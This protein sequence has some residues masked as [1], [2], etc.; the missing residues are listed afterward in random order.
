MP[1]TIADRVGVV[2]IGRN[3]GER[4]VACLRSAAG[5]GGPVVYVDSASTDGSVA[6]ARRLGADTVALDMAL[7]FT[8][9]RARNAGLARLRE[10]AP[11]VE[12]V[13]FVDADCTLA[14]GWLAVATRFLAS[15]PHV[16]VVCG[17]RRE[18]HPDA[19]VYN[20]MCDLEWDTPVGR[21]LACGG[22]ALMR[23]DA[24]AAVGG[25]NPALIAGEEPELCVRLREAGWEIWRHDAEM[26]LHEAD[27]TRFGQWWRRTLR[28]G[29]AFAEVSHLHRRSAR[30][31]WAHETRRA[32]AWGAVLPAAVLLAAA[33]E[34]MALA[35]LAIYPLQVVRL[36]LRRGGAAPRDWA[37]AGFTVLGRFAEC[38]G[39]WRFVRSR[40]QRRQGPLIE[41]KS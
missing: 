18:R 40:L 21:A 13:Q 17:R 2:V 10:A 36:A 32:V 24:L 16:A 26:T 4:L 41:Y 15:E 33:I 7:P 14:E 6:A 25:Y 39:V 12:F 27:I 28:S 20:W 8:A 9:A 1:R 22:D 34:P 35:G 29:H 5:V 11:H 30:R 38:Q 23:V 31:I 3:E 19:S 37:F